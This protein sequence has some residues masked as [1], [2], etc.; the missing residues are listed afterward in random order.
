M[1]I[2]ILAVDDTH[3]ILDLLVNILTRQGYEVDMAGNGMEGLKMVCEKQYDLI[4]SDIDMPVMNGIEFYRELCKKMPWMKHRVL[5]V[6]AN[7]D[8]ETELCI[9]EHG[10]KHLPKPFMASELLEV[11]QELIN[12]GV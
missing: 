7:A 9:K 10:L 12:H 8:R 1:K 11:V 4:I 2:Q 5:F 6:T 3:G